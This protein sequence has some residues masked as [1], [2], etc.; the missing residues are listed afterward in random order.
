M[1]A[2]FIVSF[3]RAWRLDLSA[4][5]SGHVLAGEGKGRSR[6]VSDPQAWPSVVA[7]VPAR[8]EA[9]LIAQSIGSLL[10]QDYPGDF[11]VILVDDQSSDETAKIAQNLQIPTGASRCYGELRGLQAGPESCWA[12]KTGR[13]SCPAKA[14]AADYLWLTD[15][16]IAHSKDN[17]R[18]LVARAEHDDLVLVSLMAKLRC[19]SLAERFL[20]PAFVFFFQMLFPFAWVNRSDN[21]VAAAAGGCM[22]LRRDAFEEAGG[23]DR[24]RREIIDDCALAR[25]MKAQGPIWLGMT[26]RAVSL[27]RYERLRDIRQM[28]SRSAYAQLRYSPAL[29]AGTIAGMA[30]IYA[31]PVLIAIFGAGAARF[32]AGLCWLCMTVAFQPILA[33]YRRMP[34]WGLALPLIGLF[35]AAFTVHSAIQ[36]GA[37]GA[38]CGKA[39]RKP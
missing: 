24:V 27:R 36:H 4:R 10:A 34:F 12:L 33:F 17:L 15:A 19:E 30:V 3:S 35:Y 28:V 23:I 22:L 9:E 8:D 26:E 21:P 14:F 25:R 16:D 1:S 29:L 2:A 6:P 7:V 32:E 18:H 11:R 13:C 5:L 37:A 31:A 20:I 39:V 38:A